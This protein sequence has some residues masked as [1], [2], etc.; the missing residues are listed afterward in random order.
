MSTSSTK[1]K[2]KDQE[3]KKNNPEK[4]EADRKAYE[5]LDAWDNEHYKLAFKDNVYKLV[6]KDKYKENSV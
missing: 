5:D 2:K 6:L 4:C 1:C 3:Y